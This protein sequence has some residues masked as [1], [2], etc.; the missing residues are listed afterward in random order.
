MGQSRQSSREGGWQ[1]DQAALT[2]GREKDSALLIQNNEILLFILTE[3]ILF[4]AA[5]Q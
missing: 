3:N 1:Q 4:A 5:G 2:E